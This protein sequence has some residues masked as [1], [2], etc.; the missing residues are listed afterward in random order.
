MASQRHSDYDLN[1]TIIHSGSLF[2][3]LGDNTSPRDPGE[4]V[5][6]L[7]TCCNTSTGAS[8]TTSS[9]HLEYDT[10][11]SSRWWEKEAEEILR[12]NT[13]LRN[14]Q[15]VC[16]FVP[17]Q[18]QRLP[19]VV[20]SNRWKPALDAFLT[21]LRAQQCDKHDYPNNIGELDKDQKVDEILRRLRPPPLPRGRNWTW[22]P[23]KVITDPGDIAVAIDQEIHFEDWIKV[24][25][26]YFSDPVALSDGVNLVEE[27]SL[28]TNL[29]QIITL[30]V[31]PGTENSKSFGI[32]G[33]IK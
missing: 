12:T 13:T 21:S 7:Q 24:A 11:L 25:L 31:T 8:L 19:R 26:G 17:F 23:P 15:L 3:F 28:V 18:S 29:S 33:C 22:T 10:T 2:G 30:T 32:L 9:E 4:S 16:R 14:L 20:L 27:V 5:P 1:T 6:P